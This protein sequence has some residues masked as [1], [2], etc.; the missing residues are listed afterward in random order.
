MPAKAGM[1]KELLMLQGETTLF[2]LKLH[3]LFN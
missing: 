2:L 1:E 3:K